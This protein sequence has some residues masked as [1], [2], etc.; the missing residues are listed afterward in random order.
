M[1]DPTSPWLTPDEAADRLRVS[2]DTL[3]RWRRHDTG[4]AW[5]RA[6]D[7]LVR[8]RTTDIDAWVTSSG[9]VGR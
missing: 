7:R 3:R 1:P 2:A 5:H 6:G 9:E 4:P 8:Y